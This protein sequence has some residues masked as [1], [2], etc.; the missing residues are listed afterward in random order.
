MGASYQLP[1]ENISSSVRL[2]WSPHT[3][4]YWV[5]HCCWGLLLHRC[6]LV[7]EHSCSWTYLSFYRYF[8]WLGGIILTTEH[9]CWGTLAH[10]WERTVTHTG[11]YRLQKSQRGQ[12]LVSYE[13]L[14]S[15]WSWGRTRS[16]CRGTAGWRQSC[17]AAALPHHTPEIKYPIPILVFKTLKTLLLRKSSVLTLLLKNCDAFLEGLEIYC[18]YK[19][20]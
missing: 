17:I 4:W 20:L 19:G 16:W 10:C 6:W 1:S 2:L 11:S 8:W 12:I 5:T 7:V 3:V 18:F 9:C 13:W 15:C 14:T